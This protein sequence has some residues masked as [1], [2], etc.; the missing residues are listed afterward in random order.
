MTDKKKKVSHYRASDRDPVLPTDLEQ[1]LR[2]RLR[3]DEPFFNEL[4]ELE[5]SHKFVFHAIKLNY[6]DGGFM[7]MADILDGIMEKLS[8]DNP[9]SATAYREFFAD[10]KAL[11]K[12]VGSMHEIG[13]LE[14]KFN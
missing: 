1:E 8:K 10:C 6:T 5:K 12:F 11:R 4:D 13:Q 14:I 3:K 2:E 9:V 7:Q